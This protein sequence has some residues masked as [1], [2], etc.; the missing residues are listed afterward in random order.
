MSHFNPKISIEACVH[1]SHTTPFYG[2]GFIASRSDR[3]ALGYDIDLRPNAFLSNIAHTDATLFTLDV[4][5]VGMP[6]LWRYQEPISVLGVAP[7][8]SKGETPHVRHS[9]V[10]RS[11]NT[12]NLCVLRIS[13]MG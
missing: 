10:H 9:K 8:S 5:V 11:G 1:H 2:D 13:C 12:P 3:G 7:H 4:A 6:N